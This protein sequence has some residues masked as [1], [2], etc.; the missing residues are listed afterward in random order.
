MAC[1]AS[2]TQRFSILFSYLAF[3]FLSSR[4][5]QNDMLHLYLVKVRLYKRSFFAKQA[6]K[7]LPHFSISAQFSKNRGVKLITYR[8]LELAK[9]ICAPNLEAI[10][11]KIVGALWL[12]ERRVCMRVCKH[13]CDVKMFA[14]RALIT[15][16]HEFEKDFE[17]KNSTSLLYLPI[18]SSVETWKIFRNMLG[19]FIFAWAN[20]LSEK[21]PYFGKHLF[22][23]TKYW[24][25][26]QDSCTRLRD[27]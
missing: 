25:R 23:K 3:C 16:K 7:S 20:I 10:I 19:P 11:T 5:L 21:N 22:C 8:G 17:L 2:C 24:L 4:T 14:F 9:S 12:V 18:S 1:S 15:R 13:G 26:V 27:W 6:T